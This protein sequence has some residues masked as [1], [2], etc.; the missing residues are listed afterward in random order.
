MASFGRDLC[1]DPA[2][3]GSREWLVTNGIG[4]FAAGTISG[5]L[6]R[7]YHGLLIAALQPP[8]GRTLLCAK[9]DESAVYDG[10]TYALGTNQWADRTVDPAGYTCLERFHREGVIPVWTYAC[11]DALLEKRVWMQRGA[12]TTY[13]RYTC[14]RGSTPLQLT[15]KMLVNYRDFHG[16]TRAGDWRMDIAEVAHGLRVLARA[17]AEPFYLLCDHGGAAPAH[18]WYRNYRLELEIARGFEGIEDHLMAGTFQVELPPGESVAIIASTQADAG[19]NAAAA[20]TAQR[21]HDEQMLAAS[22]LT[23]AGEPIRQLV[24]AAD[25]FV[26]ERPTRDEPHGQTIIAGYPWFGDWGR[27]TMISLPGLTLATGRPEVCRRILRTFA[28]Y[29]DQGMLPNRFPDAGE[30]PQYNTV[31]ATLWYFEALRAYQ[32]ETHDDSLVKEL[33]PALADIIDWHVKGTR[34]HIQVDPADGL[35][36]AGEPGV[37]LTWMDAKVGDWVVTPRTGKA[38]EINALW[39]N[40]LRSMAGLAPVAGAASEGYARRADQ[41]RDSFKRFWNEE[42]GYCFDV[43]DGPDGRDPSLRPNQLLAVS[44]AH[45]PLTTDRQKAVVDICAR[46]LLTSHGLRSL[47]AGDPR[48]VGH[49]GGSPQQRDGAYHQGTVWAWLIGPFVDAVLR[50]TGDRAQARRYLTPLLDNLGGGCIG[51]LSEIYDGAAPFQRR[52]CFAQAW[53]VAEVLRAWRNTQG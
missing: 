2:F 53:S 41:V 30:T 45:S 50:V 16:A 1:G 36:Y 32:E 38:V 25:Q 6:T 31:D 40:A 15:L 39:Y 33:Y 35:L 17:D 37:Q 27:D 5:M 4:G 19:L 44:L 42:A 7:R 52:G 34:Y 20:Y 24:L 13:I 18:D 51:S 49:Y 29:I 9:I 8:L 47:S 14:A 21:Y 12:N 10:A 43:I 46:Q 28:Q 11:A 26:V 3:A 23:G 22:R 48:Y